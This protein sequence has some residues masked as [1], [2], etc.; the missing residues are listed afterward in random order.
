MLRPGCDQHAL[1]HMV[2]LKHAELEPFIIKLPALQAPSITLICIEIAG[3]S[4]ILVE[5]IKLFA[6]I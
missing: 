5:D 4:I 3:I 1:D 2:R 6:L